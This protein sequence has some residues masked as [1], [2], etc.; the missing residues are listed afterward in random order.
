MK[1]FTLEPF[2]VK[3]Y[4]HE[5]VY[6]LLR[7]DR[8]IHYRSA[9]FILISRRKPGS[10]PE[11]KPFHG[12]PEISASYHGK[13]HRLTAPERNIESCIGCAVHHRASETKHHRIGAKRSQMRLRLS[14]RLVN[15]AAVDHLGAHCIHFF[16]K[17]FAA[18]HA[19]VQQH[20]QRIYICILN[21]T[22]A[23][24]LAVYN[25]IFHQPVLCAYNSRFQIFLHRI[26]SLLRRFL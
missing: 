19:P 18:F 1:I 14:D 12:Q 17:L 20:H 8:K 26:D 6:I 10:F 5:A 7:I 11:S 9:S 23:A 4:R 25:G 13:Q 2:G 15:A 3:S 24:G 16:G 21:G 22:A